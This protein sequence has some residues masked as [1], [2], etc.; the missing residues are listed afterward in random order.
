MRS[1]TSHR[2]YA[3]STTANA[4]NRSRSQCCVFRDALLAVAL[5]ANEGCAQNLPKGETDSIRSIV[6]QA[7]RNDSCNGLILSSCAIGL[8]Y[9]ILRLKIGIIAVLVL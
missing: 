9:P 2:L 8:T 3:D 4:Y 6:A 1:G 5:T 7:V